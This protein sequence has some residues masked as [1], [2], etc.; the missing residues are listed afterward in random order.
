M[1]SPLFIGIQAA[2]MQAPQAEGAA[3]FL[4]SVSAGNRLATDKAVMQALHTVDWELADRYALASPQARDDLILGQLGLRGEDW[5]R[6]QRAFARFA[7]DAGS[8]GNTTQ[9]PN[10]GLS[11]LTVV[12]MNSVAALQHRAKYPS[13]EGMSHAEI[14]Q[15]N[16]EINHVES[17]GIIPQSVIEQG[18]F[19]LLLHKMKAESEALMERLV[20]STPLIPSHFL[21]TAGSFLQVL[22]SMTDRALRSRQPQRLQE[23]LKLQKPLNALRV[24]SLEGPLLLPHLADSFPK[25]LEIEDVQRRINSAQS[26]TD[27]VPRGSETTRRVIAALFGL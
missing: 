26:Y 10:A 3:T 23:T 18:R 22:L 16:A 14:L 17:F 2:V 12:F 11:A 9:R 27:Q 25:I 4:A 13:L 7:P 24:L 15:F 19:V 6:F 8:Y 21:E 5:G 1:G 20:P